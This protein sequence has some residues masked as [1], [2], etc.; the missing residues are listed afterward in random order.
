MKADKVL[1]E[2]YIG[3]VLSGLFFMLVGII[4]VRPAWMYALGIIVGMA[5]ACFQAYHMYD[6]LDRGLELRSDKAKSF[7]TIRSIFR[8]GICLVLMAIAIMIHWAA[9]VGVAIGLICLKFSAFLNPF[10]TKYINKNKDN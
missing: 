5:G 9:F 2:L 8:L 3:I 10:I 4:F 6:T 7:V 1:K